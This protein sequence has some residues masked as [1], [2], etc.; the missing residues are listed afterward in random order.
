MAMIILKAWYLETVL[1]LAQV[2]N[3][4]PGR[5]ADL[6]LS[7][8]GL[9]KTG[10]RADLLDD[11]EQ[12]R[13]SLWF[14]RYLRGEV[15][16]FYLEGSGVYSIA[17]LDLISR[18][19]YFSK[20]ATFHPLQ[21]T[22]FWAAPPDRQHH[23]AWLE[24]TLAYVNQHCQPLVPL[25]LVASPEGKTVHIDAALLRNLREALLII[26]DVGGAAS[27][28][29]YFQLGYA[30]Q[31]KRPQQIILLGEAG[32]PLPVDV[33]GCRYADNAAALTEGV[34]DELQRLGVIKPA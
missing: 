31:H 18:E 10:L 5:G 2:A 14:E 33:E 15:V 20:R 25:T 3:V 29:V 1:S 21:P 24:Q 9:L 11:L 8:T 26:A 6:R 32:D 16:E 27:A 30:L 23:Q 13:Q 19:I 34:R 7:Q 28:S 17:N 22:L 12:V 4:Y